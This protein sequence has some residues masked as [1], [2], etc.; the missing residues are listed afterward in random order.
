MHGADRRSTAVVSAVA[1]LTTRRGRRLVTTAAAVATA[2]AAAFGSAGAH[3]EAAV[4]ENNRYLKLTPLGDRVRVAYTIFV[5][6][7]PG[8]ALRRRLDRDRDGQLD[9]REAAAYGD[10][11]AALVR[12][13]V[14]VTLDGELAPVAWTTIDVGLG[15]PS[16]AGGAFSVDLVGW[17]CARGPRHQ[18]VLRDTVRLDRPGET[19][20]RLEDGPGVRFVS[21]RLGDREMDALD[22]KW[23]GGDGPLTL[24]LDVTWEVDGAAARPVD[25]KCAAGGGAGAGRRRWLGYGLGVA[26]AIAMAGGALWARRRRSGSGSG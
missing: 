16:V 3:V 2:C 18:L 6:E 15:T 11:V 5:G 9:D 12:P 4:D 7:R 14:T 23:T 22:A 10:E 1:H 13:A 8:A 24:G 26:A 19:E 20:V 17:I 21:R 25:G